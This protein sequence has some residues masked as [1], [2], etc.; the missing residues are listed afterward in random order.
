VGTGAV[1][2]VRTLV[3]RVRDTVV[4]LIGGAGI[5]ASVDGRIT[6]RVGVQRTRVERRIEGRLA[7]VERSIF[8]R[9]IELRRLRRIVGH[10][11]GVLAGSVRAHIRILPRIYRAIARRVGIATRRAADQK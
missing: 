10:S 5:A 9:A 7:R 6:L 1:V 3:G 4:I 11:A 2:E 8:L